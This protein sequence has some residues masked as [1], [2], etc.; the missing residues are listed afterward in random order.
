MH[1]ISLLTGFA[2]PLVLPVA[3]FVVVVVHSRQQNAIQSMNGF[4]VAPGKRLRVQ[5]KQPKGQ[6]NQNQMGAYNAGGMQAQQQYP[7]KPY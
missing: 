2:F 3:L 4:Q 5:L 6:G 1:S 7:Q